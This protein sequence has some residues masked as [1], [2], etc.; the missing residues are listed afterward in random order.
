MLTAALRNEI[1]KKWRACW[2]MS[3]AKPLV[4]LDLLTWLLLFKIVEERQLITEN[5]TKSSG[6]NFIY[7]KENE[8]RW[9]NFKN[10][11]AQS[12][13]K[14]FTKENGLLDF[15]K[16]YGA[17]NLLYSA[18]IKEPLLLIPTPGLL[19]N[20]VDIIKTMEAEDVVTRAAIYE[21]L[22]NKIEIIAQNGQ[23]YAPDYIVKLSVAL[24]EPDAEDVIWDPL[25]G[26]CSFLVNS[27]MYVAMAA[28]K[29]DVVEERYKGF[30]SDIIQLR[31]GAVNMMLHGIEDPKLEVSKA[32]QINNIS[33]SDHPTLILSNLIFKGYDNNTNV[34]VKTD[35][36]RSREIHFL[37]RILKSLKRGGR[38]VVIVPEII[39][40]DS[41]KDIK[42]IRQRVIDD[43]NLQAIIILPN[44][45][46]SLFSGAGILIFA[47]KESEITEKVWFYKMKTSKQRL[48]QNGNSIA[49][50]KNDVLSFTEEYADVLD[51][52]NRWKNKEEETVRKRTDASFYV[53]ADEI[54]N[55]NYNLYY[56]EYKKFVKESYNDEIAITEEEDDE[57]DEEIT[58][59][60][61]IKKNTATYILK[62]KSKVK[63]APEIRSWN[64]I[65]ERAT[66]YIQKIKSKVK[67]APAI[68]AWNAIKEHTTPYIQKIKSKVKLA[69]AI[70][71]WNAIKEHTT[72]YIQKIKSKVKVAPAIKAWNA[73]K[74][75]ATPYIQKI[76]LKAQATP[77][78]KWFST[79]LKLLVIIWIGE[80]AFTFLHFKDH[81]IASFKKYTSLTDTIKANQIK[82]MLKDT[83]GIIQFQ[84]QSANLS[85]SKND[86]GKIVAK[87]LIAD[88]LAGKISAGI[89]GP[90][91]FNK[92]L[93]VQYLVMDTTFFHDKPDESTR[94]KSYLDPLKNVVLK[95]MDDRNGFIY[96][97]YT[98]HFGR[99][100]KGW[101][102]KKDLKQLP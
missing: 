81:N 82:A 15:M 77:R 19:A 67:V 61:S 32:F 99:T 87:Y 80:V 64:A 21:Y 49:T 45:T 83:T 58:T 34:G 93:N 88:T 95:P 18:I 25:A 59:W 17:E 13:Y 86:S 28:N 20:A 57:D 39:L 37:N 50:G 73:I 100:S 97:S 51:I 6:D 92:A 30:D 60:N 96:I 55:N 10:L 53:E 3:E 40:Y 47:K 85:H 46:G 33:L 26:N 22:L 44:K 102:N 94:R 68:K 2:P 48:T 23:V 65:K 89:P 43:H 1:D 62:I 78:K 14:L 38:A 7:T 12:R 69:P 75:H 42:A 91:T 52:L 4:L 29:T 41:G 27:A 79:I 16:N 101:I 36:T 70:K 90:G 56:N 5:S 74:E 84:S 35:V 11:D 31:I 24:M 98:N 72:L 76:K 63:V 71:A 8:L 66:P 9:S 54:K